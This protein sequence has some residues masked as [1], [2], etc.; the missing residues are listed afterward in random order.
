MNSAQTAICRVL[1]RAVKENN[2][3]R[4]CGIVYHSSLLWQA[5]Y[6]HEIEKRMV[7]VFWVACDA[8]LGLPSGS[9][10]AVLKAVAKRVKVCCYPPGFNAIQSHTHTRKARE[11][12][13]AIPQVLEDDDE[14]QPFAD[15]FLEHALAGNVG[16]LRILMRRVS[17]AEVVSLIGDAL[18]YSEEDDMRAEDAHLFCKHTLR[19]CR[20]RFRRRVAAELLVAVRGRLGLDE[21]EGEE[22]GEEDVLVTPR[23]RRVLALCETPELWDARSGVGLFC[24]FCAI[25][26]VALARAVCRRMY[27]PGGVGMRKSRDRFSQRLACSAKM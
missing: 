8:A 15:M 13:L 9:P 1:I 4:V 2:I 25:K 21:E 7:D 22:E 14:L 17:D 26:L 10:P 18:F 23:W 3:R 12:R 27:E 5:S 20:G 11:H 19:A 24:F 16:V 6:D